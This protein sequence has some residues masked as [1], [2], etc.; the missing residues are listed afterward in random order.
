MNVY[1]TYPHDRD[2][3]GLEGQ[4]NVHAEGVPLIG[5]ATL[6]G[7]TDR[8]DI[9]WTQTNKPVSCNGCLAIIEQVKRE[10]CGSAS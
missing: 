10:H 9:A 3:D 7:H 4:H 2:N 1:G 5:S 8:P 6:C